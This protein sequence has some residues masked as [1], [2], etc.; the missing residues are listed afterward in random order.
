MIF[1]M[2]FYANEILKIIYTIIILIIIKTF[3]KKDY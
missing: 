2:N 1:M 3:K